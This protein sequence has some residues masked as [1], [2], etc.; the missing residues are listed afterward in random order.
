LIIVSIS[1]AHHNHKQL[2]FINIVI[3][4][5]FPPTYTVSRKK[6]NYRTFRFGSPK[7]RRW[8][9]MLICYMCRTTMTWDISRWSRIYLALW[10]HNW[11]KKS[12]ENSFAIDIYAINKKQ[13]F[14]L[15][16]KIIK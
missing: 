3:K 10:A 7:R 5:T 9:S 16:I 1:R 8:I 13:N 14:V 12:T 2:T 6:R 11:A 15:K 4:I